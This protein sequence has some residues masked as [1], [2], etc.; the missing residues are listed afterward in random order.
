MVYIW[1]WELCKALPWLALAIL[2]IQ[3]KILC[4]KKKLWKKNAPESLR[5]IP[6]AEQLEEACW[7]GLM[8]DL[9][10]DIIER[11][12]SGKR[13]SLW[14]IRQGES[15]LEIDLCDYQQPIEKYL[16]INPRFFMQAIFYN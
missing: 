6:Q 15:L 10:G 9:L 2:Y 7:N 3:K 4:F 14:R 12:A 1:P 16:S 5:H 13:L 8:D 11:S